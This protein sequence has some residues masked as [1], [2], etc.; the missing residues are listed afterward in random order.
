MQQ[1]DAWGRVISA[2]PDATTQF[3]EVGP[4]PTF[5]TGMN[6]PLTRWQMTVALAEP[7]LP[8]I[9]GKP[10]A[11]E[12]YVKNY[13]PQSASG[14]LRLIAPKGWR[15][16]PSTIDFQISAGGDMSR[17]LTVTFP[18]GAT[19]GPQD[20]TIEFDI[21]VDREYKF[22][23][24]RQIEV[25]LGEFTIEAA[26]QLT[27]AGDLIVEQRIINHTAQIT[28]WTC[29]LFVPNRRRLRGYVS[30]SGRGEHVTSYVIRDATQL[31]GQTLWL[32]CRQ[33]RGPRVLNH[34]FV[35]EP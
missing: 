5:V 29:D 31:V 35:V 28:G 14:Q 13:F 25:G 6:E 24:A 12:L 20:V 10:H 7:Q 34:R 33:T 23:V 8:S 26:T 15:I 4:L 1:S 27:D 21:T 19:S 30:E 22:S 2:D 3:I 11:N 18:F 17:P 9:Y 16:E 32:K